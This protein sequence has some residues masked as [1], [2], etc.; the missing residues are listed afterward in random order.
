VEWKQLEE[1]AADLSARGD[2]SGAKADY[3][4]ILFNDPGNNEVRVKLAM[5]C[6]RESNFSEALN[7]LKIAEA[8]GCVNESLFILKA[9]IYVRE[10]K[11]K[12]A[13]A[14]LKKAFRCSK[15]SP[16]LY[17]ELGQVLQL[18]HKPS[19]AL[20]AWMDGIFCDP[21]YPANYGAAAMELMK[22]H[23]S[24]EGLL[25]AEIYLNI[26]QDTG[27]A[28]RDWKLKLYQGYCSYFN[29]LELDGTFMKKSR[30]ASTLRR[31]LSGTEEIDRRFR[32]ILPTIGNDCSSENL[33]MIRTRFILNRSGFNSTVDFPLFRYHDLMLRAGWF[34]LYN[35]WLFGAAADSVQFQ[36]F[37]R[38]HPGSIDSFNTWRIQHPLTMDSFGHQ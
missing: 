22:Q 36:S 24:I 2:L 38:Y 34:D 19:K 37:N 21:K 8:N 29:A 27:A 23:E 32:S 31:Q 4:S 16:V 6:F 35:Q 17:Y 1:D 3:S 12:S 28:V 20:K 14:I 18:K 15:T 11:L 7:Q 26:S 13:V 33:A 30:A 25:L 10:H 9:H 5:V